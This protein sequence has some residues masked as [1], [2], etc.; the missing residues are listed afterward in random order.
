MGAL[1]NL[2]PYIARDPDWW[3]DYQGDVPENYRN[4]WNM[5]KGPAPPGWVAAVAPDGN[6]MMTFYRKDVFEKLGIE[7]P[8]TW[9]DVIEVAKEIHD[10]KNERY[11]YCAAMAR[12]F[13]AGYQF[14]G[15]PQELGRRLFR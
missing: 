10:P 12:N 3:E 13:W 7:V 9:T 2:D 1:T 11:A 5:P 8:K 14:Y 15:A 6:A 4:M